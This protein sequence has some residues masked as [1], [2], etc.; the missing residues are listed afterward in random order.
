M[1][2]NTYVLC[3]GE[4]EPHDSTTG[5]AL[6]VF[7]DLYI[8]LSR[9]MKSRMQHTVGTRFGRNIAGANR[10]HAATRA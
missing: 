7:H 6:D 2:L 10:N 8:L 5:D 1:H 3:Y 9:R 4:A